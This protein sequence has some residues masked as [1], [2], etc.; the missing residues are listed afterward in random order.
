[1]SGVLH[2]QPAAPS[3][4]VLPVPPAQPRHEVSADVPSALPAHTR[5]DHSTHV[6]PNGMPSTIANEPATALSPSVRQPM[7]KRHAMM[8]AASTRPTKRRRVS[9]SQLSQP[10]PPVVHALQAPLKGSQAHVS[11]QQPHQHSGQL[12]SGQQLNLM[13]HPICIYPTAADRQRHNSHL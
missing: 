6:Q 11:M 8:P 3:L 7:R 9:A 13:A 4:S 10:E 12:E 2:A 1:M 5:L